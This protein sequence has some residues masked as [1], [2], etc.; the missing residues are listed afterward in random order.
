MM[1]IEAI[2]KILEAYPATIAA[3]AAGIAAIGT[4]IAFWSNL[5][6]RRQYKDSIQPQLSMS[7]FEVD[8]HLY[9]EIK[10]TGGLPANNIQ[11][12]VKKIRNNGCRDELTLDPLF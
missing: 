12:K 5:Q 11:I 1:E 6:N 7:L 8:Y 10:N 4:V 2:S 3:I 9:L